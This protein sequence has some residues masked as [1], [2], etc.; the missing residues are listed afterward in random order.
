MEFFSD[1]IKWAQLAKTV[2]SRFVAPLGTVSLTLSH[3]MVKSKNLLRRRLNIFWNVI[4]LEE[5]RTRHIIPRGLHIQLFPSFEDTPLEFKTQWEQVLNECSYKLMPILKQYNIKELESIKV[6]QK[7]LSEQ[8]REY[9]TKEQFRRIDADLKTFMENLNLRGTSLIMIT[10]RNYFKTLKILLE[11]WDDPRLE[12]KQ[13]VLHDI[14]ELWL[15]GSSDSM[16]LPSCK[17]KSCRYPNF[18]ENGAIEIFVRRVTEDLLGMTRNINFTNLTQDEFFKLKQLRTNPNITIKPSDKGS[19]IVIMN[20]SQY[21][22]MCESSK[23]DP[24][25]HKCIRDPPGRPIVSGCGSLTEP[26][27]GSLTEPIIG[28]DVEALYMSIPH[29]LGLKAIKSLF[30]QIH[31]PINEQHNFILNA[32]DFVLH[33]NVFLFDGIHYRQCQGVAMGAKCAPSYANLYLGEWER[34]V[35]SADEYEMYLCHIL[36]WHR[37]INAIMLIWQGPEQLLKEFVTKLNT[38][39]FN[40][41]FTM[42]CDSSKLE[43]LD[44]EIK[45]NQEGLVSTIL[46]RKKT[47]SNSLLHAKSMHPSKCIEGI[48]KRQYLRLRRICSSDKDFKQEAYKLYQRFKMRGYKTRTLHRAYQW[49]VT[50]NQEDLLYKAKLI[51]TYNKNDKDIRS[52]IHKHLDILSK[53]PVLSKLVTPR[54]LF[55]YRRS[56]SI[57]DLLTH[58]HFQKQS[59]QTCCKMPCNYR[60]GSCEQCHI[61]NCNLLSSTAKHVHCIHNGNY[62]GSYFQGIDQ[63]HRDIRGGDLDNKLLQLETTW[64]FRLNT[65]KMEFGLNGHLNFQ[66][67]V[68]K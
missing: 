4:C 61:R 3:L 40:L 12:E 66:A 16:K 56:T 68:N 9:E 65:Y 13:E 2:F 53:D 21:V 11:L 19:N 23:N 58:S 29:S 37:Y 43:F 28:L 25:V 55:S 1:D 51:M 42:I 38:N 57:G 60:C 47:A 33:H 63:L 64:I 22:I 26:I 18:S 20:S 62:T 52:I 17:N 48:P 14:Q 32:L 27:S 46:Y 49:A 6:Q 50:Q 36:R 7:Q 35:F 59:R 45:K 44:I 24:K 8:L 10:N 67:F 54:P 34:H 5:Y 41:S 31:K 30:E 39:N 15:E